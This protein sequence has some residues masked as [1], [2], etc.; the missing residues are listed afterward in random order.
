[1]TIKVGSS[2]QSDARFSSQTNIAALLKKSTSTAIPQPRNAEASQ[3]VRNQDSVHLESVL[4]QHDKQVLNYAVGGVELTG[5]DGMK[6]LNFMAIRIAL[7]RTT[8]ALS[9]EIDST[10]MQR[11]AQSQ[12]ITGDHSIA[13]SSIDRAIEFLDRKRAS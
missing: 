4:T 13:S 2:Q 5:M 9:G 8:G 3:A 7:D 6:K 10:Y 11:I 1:M 12:K